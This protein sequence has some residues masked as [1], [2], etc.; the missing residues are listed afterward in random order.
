MISFMELL[1]N[2]KN[3]FISQFKIMQVNLFFYPFFFVQFKH[4]RNQGF[5]LGNGLSRDLWPAAT[6]IRYDDESLSGKSSGWEAYYSLKC[7]R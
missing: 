5:S 2:N 6:Y 7:E 1:W 4:E 3:P